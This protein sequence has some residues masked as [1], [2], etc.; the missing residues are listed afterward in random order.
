[1]AFSDDDQ[2]A[3]TER[4]TER[5]RREARE[6]GMVPRSTELVIASRTLVTWVVV[7]LWAT[8]FTTSAAQLLLDSFRHLSNEHLNIETALPQANQIILWALA[9]VSTP[10][11]IATGA[12][13][14]AHFVQVGWLWQPERAALD[15]TR[16]SPTSGLARLMSSATLGRIFLSLIKLSLFSII[17]TRLIC[18]EW[19]LIS[20]SRD[21]ALRDQVFVI[22]RS[23]TRLISSVA[24]TVLA[25][26]VADY[27]L[28][29]WRFERSL[30][31]TK[32]ELRQES[33]DVEGNPHIRHQR[34]A[35]AR[36]LTAQTSNTRVS[37]ISPQF[38]KQNGNT[39]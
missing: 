4:P 20:E 1:M 33:K 2:E 30:Q 24:I 22:S 14:V 5:H 39:A 3:R 19:P 7:S 23:A 18:S 8:S 11:L 26:G 15:V 13:L 25:W 36:Q 31:M 29:R 27:F 10:L 32:E 6:R 12:V 21:L 35:A 37:T 17:C 16:L 28:Q 38:R 9:Q 34:Q